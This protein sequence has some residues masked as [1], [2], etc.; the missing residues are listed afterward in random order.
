M[1]TLV[2]VK[3]SVLTV[4]DC[5][6]TTPTGEWQNE[7]VNASGQWRKEKKISVLAWYINRNW[8]Y[9]KLWGHINSA[10]I[11][12]A[13]ECKIWEVMEIHIRP[14][15]LNEQMGWWMELTYILKMFITPPHTDLLTNSDN[16]LKKNLVTITKS[17]NQ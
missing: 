8:T 15:C 5:V 12:H 3:Y 1:K 17:V 6:W 9:N 4:I 2:Y 10:T 16:W 14:S 7:E 11:T 13:M